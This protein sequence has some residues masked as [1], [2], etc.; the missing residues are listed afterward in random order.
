MGRFKDFPMDNMFIA[1]AYTEELSIQ[2]LSHALIDEHGSAFA[3]NADEIRACLTQAEKAYLVAAY[4]D[5]QAECSPSLDTLSEDQ[6]QEVLDA[7]KKFG[8]KA[9]SDLSTSSLKRLITTLVSRPSK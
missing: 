4:N 9:L 6:A 3:N 1:E 8:E 5:W 2:V 7:V